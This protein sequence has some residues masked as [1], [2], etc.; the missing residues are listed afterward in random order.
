VVAE[1]TGY[2]AGSLSLGLALDADLGVDSIK[3]V[4]ILSALQD[5]LPAA[6]RVGPEHLGR[7]HTLQDV[8]DFLAG[9]AADH[10]GGAPVPQPPGSP[11]P[12]GANTPGSPVPVGEVAQ[13]LI[14]VVAEK[15]GYPAGSLSLGLALD[16]D[17]GVDSIKRVEILSALQD[18]LPAAPRVG[19]EHLG[20]LHTLQDVADFLAGRA[21]GPPEAPATAKIA[22]PPPPPAAPAPAVPAPGPASRAADRIDRSILQA[23]DLDPAAP[24]PRVALPPGAEVWVV[25]EPGDLTDA[26]AAE[27]RRRGYHS[28]VG[29]WSPAGLPGAGSPAGLV[30]LAPVAPGPDSGL[31]RL[32]FEWL[33]LAGPGLRA[34]GRSGGAAFATVARLDGAFGLGDLAPDADPTAGGLAGLAKTARH[35]WP[36]VASK[37]IDLDPHF[38]DPTA[39]A[40]A[41]ADE[42]LLAGPAEVGVAA[43]SRCTLEPARAVRRPADGP[44]LGPGDVV[45]V[46]GGGRGVTAEC[47]VALAAAFRPTLVLTGRT[48]PPGPEPDWMRDLSTEAAIKEAIA[49]RL[50]SDA[51]PR[52]IGEEYQRVAAQREVR[53]TLK[54]IRDAG[55][56]AEYLAADAADPAA[57]AHLLNHVRTRFG[58]VAALVH[59]AG[60]LADKRIEDLAPADFERV[61][62]TKVDGL[63]HLL[64]GLAADPLRAVVLFSSVT[65]RLGRTGQAAYAAANEVLNKTAQ[66]EA[67]RRPGCRVV[68]VNWGPWDGGMVTP[69]LRKQFEAEG[70]GV[71]GLADGGAF[72]ADELAAA[73][74]AVEVLALGRPGAAPPAGARPAT[75]PPADLA[76]AF[77]RAVDI[78]SHP[79]LGS[80]VIDGRAVLPVALHLEFL[81][82]AALHGNPGLVFH[83]VNDLRITKGVTLGP[84]EA[85]T[86]RAFAGRAAKRDGQLVVPVEL[87]ARRGNGQDAVRSRAEVVLVPELPPPPAADRPPALPPYPVSVDRAYADGLFH[88]PALRG[89]LA[90]TGMSDAGM[91]GTARPAPPPADWLRAPHRSAWVADPLVLDGSFQMMCL[92]CR[93]QHG[94]T[95][96]PSFVGRFRQFRRR[97]P[98]GPVTVAARV[99]RDNGTFVRADLDYRDAD[100]AV[101]AQVQDYECMIDP[102]LNAAFRRNRLEAPATA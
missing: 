41:V 60:V 8:A 26:V 51:G 17:L 62:R 18:R 5:R 58:P 21:G 12:P 10:T 45:L 63:R 65:A 66:A 43:R 44:P 13:A 97:F 95:S 42:V 69:A 73:G 90:L 71:V 32:A 79:V 4:E 30:L 22:V 46:T 33:K 37:A 54:R 96:L 88:G 87:R 25:G 47:A 48:P 24:R 77:E 92:W 56:R 34:A 80:H 14:E 16:A 84:G 3:R 61:Y 57:V 6:P 7:L 100:G 102:K 29:G 40:A 70:V 64:A 89:L 86:V 49:G 55:G 53:R 9:P 1:K 20:R 35:E 85:A 74:R 36:E 68:A 39:A 101:V 28:R 72:L 38:V 99:T 91:T 31:N 76:L 50:G 93:H 11:A 82:H 15:T 2:P 19:P 78:D 75:P 52:K 94:A 98:D 83:G 59:G 67:R 27:F 81:A 23:V